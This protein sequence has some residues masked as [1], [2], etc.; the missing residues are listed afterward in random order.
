MQFQRFFKIF[1]LQLESQYL[2]LSEPGI[3]FLSFGVFWPWPELNL[4]FYGYG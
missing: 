2:I 3:I 1:S 4:T